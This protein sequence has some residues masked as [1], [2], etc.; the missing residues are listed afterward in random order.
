MNLEEI[1][2]NINY[3][4][5]NNQFLESKE[6]KP[7]TICLEG[8]H[9][10]GKTAIVEEIAK[11]R[12]MQFTKINLGAIE[13]VGDLTGFPIKKYA[14][15]SPEGIKITV[16]E[17]S[18][19]AHITAGYNLVPGSDPVMDYAVPAWVPTEEMGPNILVLDDYSRANPMILQATMELLDKGELGAWKLPKNTQ[20]LLTSNPDNG[21]YSVSS[22][23]DAQKTRFIT[24]D[25]DFDVKLL[26]KHMEEVNV[27][28]EFINFALLY[29]EIFGESGNA[30]KAESSK[31]NTYATGRTFMA[32]ARSLE[33]VK[34][35]A[36]TDG[37]AIALD[38]SSGIF[39]GED[40]IIG[41]SFTTFLHNKL[42]KLLTP[43]EI[44]S[45]K[46]ADVAKKLEKSIGDP[47]GT[48]TYRAD[49]ASTITFR[50]VNH[51]THQLKQPKVK[52]DP[53]IDAIIN[54]AKHP[55]DLLTADLIHA[56][57]H[58]LFKADAQRMKK[59]L[60]YPAFM[61]MLL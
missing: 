40:N 49:I 29:P 21:D 43:E 46:W 18:L 24:F 2:S 61:D 45:G 55:K 3:L 57:V 10:I 47:S 27:R 39:N 50:L 16:A 23:D 7:Y 37:Q 54:I 41:N 56:M 20:I 42:D 12:A 25:V 52:A 14:M 44:I 13:E 8:G 22:M 5:D 19:E 36:S 15:I 32:F 30:S 51:I 28:S 53:F 11:T 33:T 6:L 31:N 35:L 48:G 38:I 34:D 58:K 1:K 60:T 26:A 59:L 4:I 17:A 9:G